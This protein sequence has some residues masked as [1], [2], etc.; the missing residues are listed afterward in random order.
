MSLNDEN[1]Y[2]GATNE[3]VLTSNA[4]PALKIFA[5]GFQH[6]FHGVQSFD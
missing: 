5:P 2:N 3:A 4:I 1:I 6:G